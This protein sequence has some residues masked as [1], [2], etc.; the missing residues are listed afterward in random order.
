MKPVLM[1][2]E[3]NYDLFDMKLEDY[4]LTFDDAL[5]SQYHF[6]PLLNE[7]HT[8]KIIFVSGKYTCKHNFVRIPYPSFFYSTPAK[9]AREIFDR[10]N[11][12][13]DH[14][15]MNVSELRMMVA[16]GFELGGHGYEHIRVYPDGIKEKTEMMKDDVEKMFFWMK[17]ELRYKPTAFAYPFNNE[18]GLLTEIL[19][20]EGITEF[21]GSDRILVT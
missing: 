14:H 11:G 9:E 7:I 15:Y 8:R 2:H 20:R 5:F 17:N 13:V 19:K 6:Y 3:V 18:D 21:F 16:N 4:I 12:I 1:I 10:T